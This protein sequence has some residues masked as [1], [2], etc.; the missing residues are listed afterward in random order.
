MM[1]ICMNIIGQAYL[2]QLLSNL[3][4]TVGLL[5]FKK[6]QKYIFEIKWKDF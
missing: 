6:E 1:Q 4:K 2:I 3:G 5:H